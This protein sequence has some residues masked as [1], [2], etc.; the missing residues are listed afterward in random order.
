MQTISKEKKTALF[1]LPLA[2]L[3]MYLDFK[4]KYTD[5]QY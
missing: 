5:V 2:A 3:G 4:N 1:I